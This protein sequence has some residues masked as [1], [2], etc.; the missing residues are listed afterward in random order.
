LN[1]F[2]PYL[3]SPSPHIPVLLHLIALALS[4]PALDMIP[5]FHH[6]VSEMELPLTI[7]DSAHLSRPPCF[8]NFEP[9]TASS[10]HGAAV[11]I[12]WSSKY[13]SF[14]YNSFNQQVSGTWHNQAE[15]GCQ[16]LPVAP[17]I[18]LI[19]EARLS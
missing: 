6:Q 8:K 16:A 3:S 17:Y 2:L 1:H 18:L 9:F 12:H 13:N 15:R 5:I 7:N 19:D 4:L 14:V 11:H 10:L